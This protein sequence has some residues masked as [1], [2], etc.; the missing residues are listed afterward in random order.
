M[1]DVSLDILESVMNSSPF[2]S[3]ISITVNKFKALYAIV[4][5]DV[6]SKD[7]GFYF[8]ISKED[9]GNLLNGEKMVVPSSSFVGCVNDGSSGSIKFKLHK[10]L[11]SL[12]QVTILTRSRKF[13]VVNKEK[14]WG[15]SPL[16]LN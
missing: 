11:K 9:V 6:I 5:D 16:N 1:F 4:E 15:S 3:V 12:D 8:S 2:S 10:E 7:Y 14:S 13:D